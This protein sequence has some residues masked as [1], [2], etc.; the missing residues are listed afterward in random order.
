MKKSRKV[1]TGILSVSLVSAMCGMSAYAEETGVVTT[2]TMETFTTST[3]TKSTLT[4]PTTTDALTKPVAT[5]SIAVTGASTGSGQTTTA[6][7]TTTATGTQTTSTSTEIKSENLSDMIDMSATYSATFTD[8]D[9]T[10]TYIMKFNGSKLSVTTSADIDSA[11]IYDFE[12][13]KMTEENTFALTSDSI[14]GTLKVID[15]NTL[16]INIGSDLSITF[17][18]VNNS[19]E[20]QTTSTTVPVATTTTVN[21]SFTTT[22]VNGSYT[23]TTTSSVSGTG[24]TTTKTNAEE[25]TTTTSNKK[26]DNSNSDSPKTGVAGVGMAVAGM[27][28]AVGMA[29]ISKK[30]D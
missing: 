8:G 1:I 22:T 21:G 23:T 26:S 16:Q 6:L 28:V 24:T 29:F 17:V 7:Q 14:T 19:G 12:T 15:R 20:V 9:G 13:G 27:A 3:D 30:K 2:A 11:P 18:N 5:T 4:A 25:T 10:H